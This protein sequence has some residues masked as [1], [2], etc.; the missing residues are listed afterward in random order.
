MRRL[1]YLIPAGM[2]SACANEN[3]E[4]H[5]GER[6]SSV[7]WAS[8]AGDGGSLRYSSLAD[9]APDNVARLT[10]A[11]TW[12]VGE[13]DTTASLNGQQVSPGKFEATPLAFGDTLFLSTPY[14]RVVALDGRDGH[15]L[16]S[17]DPRAEQMGLIA[18]DRAGFVHRGV[19]S[20]LIDGKRQ[21]FHASRGTLFALDAASG[22]RVATFGDSGAVDLLA[23]ARWPASRA[24][25]GNT[26]PPV[27][28]DNVVIV[29]SAIGDRIVFERDPPGDVQAFDAHTGRRL[30]RWDPVPPVGSAERKTWEGAS[31]S[32]AGHT[33]VWAPISVDNERGLVFLPVSG[34]SNDFYGGNRLGDNLYSQSIV[35]LNARTGALIW[36]RQLVRH[37]LWDFDPASPPALTSTLRNGK[38]VAEVWLAGKTGYLYGFERETGAPIWPAVER[39][40]AKS[41][42]PGE[43]TA[44]SQPHPTRPAPFARQGFTRDD[45]VNFTPEIERRAL[46]LLGGKRMGAMFTP[47]SL[48][49][50]VQMPGWI[51]GAGWGG[52]AV[53]PIRQLLFVKSSNLPILAQL[54]PT[55]SVRRFIAADF[56]D[57]A[58]G[59]MM[60]IEDD[61]WWA[62]KK[63]A[64]IRI[65]ISKP[66]YGTLTAIDLVS[67]EHRW[68]IVLGD[69][70]HIRNHSALRGLSLP[71][72]GVAG[73][74]GGLATASGLI[75][76]TGG[77][78]VLYA[79]DALSGRELWHT[80]LG[81]VGYSN[82]MTFRATD[83]RQYVVVATGDGAGASLQAFALPYTH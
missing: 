19:A 46:A 18:D 51:G 16:W 72:L 39:T 9:V 27:V 3:R 34:V 1:K 13:F 42:V 5:A 82:P 12:S 62:L 11:W 49:G 37:D 47:P 66:P 70:P 64:P 54:A 2:L 15:Q 38:L 60:E 59:L 63:S 22:R 80:D 21:I 50:T 35:C 25:V 26:S 36:A 61:R 79:I 69:T 78:R 28:F 81:Q 58:R 29:G 31:A 40:A 52:V 76:I 20:A 68:S 44:T 65:P 4:A 41:D 8:Y 53:D 74:P 57:P 75:F 83:G 73:A 32:V 71:A 33:N 30:W 45:V 6:A 48:E 23:G 7:G 77:G 43:R 24:H 10:R 55:D 17:F 56:I 67:G 14:N